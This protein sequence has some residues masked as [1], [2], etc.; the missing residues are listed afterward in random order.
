MVN[1]DHSLKLDFHSH[2]QSHHC[3]SVNFRPTQLTV[4]TK[5]LF[6]PSTARVSSLS[7]ALVTSCDAFTDSVRSTSFHLLLSTNSHISLHPLSQVQDFWQ[8]STSI[9]KPV[10]WHLS[11]K[12]NLLWFLSYSY[13]WSV[14]RML[15]QK[16][17]YVHT[18]F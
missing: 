11:S 14:K 16:L 3:Y 2:L 12:L 8:I 13:C 15:S 6:K 18:P 9:Y 7:N 10:P 17:K 1:F 5:R 4:L